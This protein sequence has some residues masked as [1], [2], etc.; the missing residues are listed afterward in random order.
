MWN[1]EN[2]YV[3]NCYLNV[4]CPKPTQAPFWHFSR[5]GRPLLLGEGVNVSF[6]PGHVYLDLGDVI[7][8]FLRKTT[9]E[10]VNAQ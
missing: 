6:Y 5:G 10:L 7:P 9:A 4:N 2:Y 3:L 1:I 8:E